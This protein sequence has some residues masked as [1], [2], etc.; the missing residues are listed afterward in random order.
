MRNISCQLVV[1]KAIDSS[2]R[3]KTKNKIKQKKLVFEPAEGLFTDRSSSPHIKLTEHITD[4][5]YTAVIL[6]L[7]LYHRM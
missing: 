1:L 3:K 5:C 6:K 2:E 7:G 4:I